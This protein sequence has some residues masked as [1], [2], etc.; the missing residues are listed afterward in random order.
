MSRNPQLV[1]VALLACAVAMS[2]TVGCSC[3]T[4]ISGTTP[5]NGGSMNRNGGSNNNSG[6]GPSGNS[7]S[8]MMGGS[9][10]G[11]NTETP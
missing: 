6:G 2:A 1:A 3:S 11:T 7:G 5:D 8:G 10:S 4:N 9:G